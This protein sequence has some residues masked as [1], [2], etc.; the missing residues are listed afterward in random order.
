MNWDW[1]RRNNAL[2]QEEVEIRIATLCIGFSD[3]GEICDEKDNVI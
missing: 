2:N 3:I 1:L